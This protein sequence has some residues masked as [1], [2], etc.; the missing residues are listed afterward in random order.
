MSSPSPFSELIKAL[1]SIFESLINR[2]LSRKFIVWMAATYFAFKGTLSM[3]YWATMTGAYM[4]VQ[5]VLDWRT[6]VTAKP[7]L[8]T[9]D[10]KL[11]DKSTATR[12]ADEE[13]TVI[14]PRP[15]Y[16]PRVQPPRRST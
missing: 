11:D 1:L 4:S 8:N 15:Q 6:P 14:K 3:E 7:K 10:E 9:T 5:G 13:L 12:N 2:F 16:L